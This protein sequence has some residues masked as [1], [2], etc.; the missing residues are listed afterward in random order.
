MI[1]IGA[2]ARPV[3]RIAERAAG[4]RRHREFP[5]FWRFFLKE[6]PGT[7][8]MVTVTALK[9]FRSKSVEAVRPA[10]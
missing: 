4:A 2:D 7:A 6:E 8:D 1:C 3:A 9:R 5:A 10:R